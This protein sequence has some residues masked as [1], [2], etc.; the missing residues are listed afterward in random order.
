AFESWAE[1]MG[2]ILEVAGVPDFLANLDAFRQTAVDHQAEWAAFVTAW[3]TEF[4]GTGVGTAEL[5]DLAARQELFGAPAEP[6]GTGVGDTGKGGGNHSAK[7]SFGYMLRK[8]R[9]RVYAG[10]RIV[11]AKPDHSGRAQYQLL[12]VKQGGTPTAAASSTAGGGRTGNGDTII[13]FT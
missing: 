7:T 6:T 3:W 12:P 8:A 10:Y 4:G 13:E 9:D 2:G 5:Y 1:T 11:T